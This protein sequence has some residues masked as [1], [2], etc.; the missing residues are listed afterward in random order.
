MSP[1]NPLG[2]GGFDFGT[3]DNVVVWH[4][5]A[6]EAAGIRD[7]DVIDYSRMPL[8]E[9]YGAPEDGLPRPPMGPAIPLVVNHNGREHIARLIPEPENNWV[10]AVGKGVNFLDLLDVLLLGKT[11][12]LV[13]VLLA[14]AVVLIRPTRFTAAIFLFVAGN[15]LGSTLQSMPYMISFV[16]PLG[17]AAVLALDDLIAGLSAIGFLALAL[18]LDPSRRIRSNLVAGVAVM[19]L[20]VIVMPVVISDVLEIVRG[21][22]P[23]WPVAGWASF[24]ALWF[25][26]AAG[27][28][29]LLR[30]TASAPAPRSVRLAAA[31]LAFVGA[32]TILNTTVNALLPA[33]Y[34]ANLPSAAMNRN[35]V[36][37]IPPFWDL[38]GWQLR[39]YVAVA[40]AAMFALSY[41]GIRGRV[42]SVPSRFFRIVLYAALTVGAVLSLTQVGRELLLIRHL[43]SLVALYIMIRA[44]VADAG[45][46]FR[47][48]VVYII[49]A[50]L[51]IT[52]FAF[53]NV[54]DI[55][56]LAPNPLV[57]GV[58][59]FVAIALGYWVS[60]L[61]DLSGSLSLACVDAWNAWANGRV[62]EERDAL[63][64]SLGLAE[65]TRK[66]PVIAEVRAH[67][68][69]SAWRD[70]EDADFERNAEK[71]QRLLGQRNMRGLRGFANAATSGDDALPFEEDDL[72]EWRAR[73][74]L[75][76]C[77]RTD[78]AGRAQQLAKDALASANRSGLPSL[79]TL[80][81]I[82]V[83]EICPEQRTSE[84][85]RAHAIARDA[86]WPALCKSILALRANARDIGI[87]Q[88]FVD[89]RLRKIRAASAWFEVSFFN[90]EL[91]HNGA[92]IPLAEKELEL[93]LSVASART[94]T[95]D[96]VLIDALWPESEGD[97]A[98]N[99]FRVCL[100]RLRK[101]VGDAR[102]VTRVGKGYVLHPWA[103]VD[104][105][106]LASLISNYREG[107]GR[108]D[109]AELRT[110]CDALR[111][112]QSR[113]ATLGDWFF[114]FEQVLQQKLDEAE[115]LLDLAARGVRM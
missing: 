36:Y 34:S 72:P 70:G 37:D 55:L 68:A 91:R 9:R 56:P 60:G 103:D 80:A 78:D 106:R 107:G 99:A 1:L 30:F 46:V 6:S 90:A 12:F 61:R 81:S 39:F 51:V 115:R 32:L 13:V 26:Y 8:D 64:Q 112:G 23:A 40:I 7:G 82:A 52:V 50:L 108:E 79:Q 105:R 15:G 33:W 43:G 24:S 19:L 110:L 25:C 95:N 62:R 84:L 41:A 29:L 31:L 10:K 86:G 11:T 94:G 49:V 111:A 102:I 42:I 5:D 18:Y 97:A 3:F 76:L 45:P 77:A 109:A 75:I 20:T 63:L 74:A 59:T 4:E 48:I 17:Y 104:L 71:L 21:A 73:T 101:N 69:F 22:R 87:L 47:G 38:S 54:T 93:L 44:G 88:P 27:F 14:S 16:R 83:A 35:I 2:L 96:N 89:V 98:R 65:R 66:K 53:E 92:A 28:V 58:E 67:A 100:H 114:R 85:E 113:R 57:Y